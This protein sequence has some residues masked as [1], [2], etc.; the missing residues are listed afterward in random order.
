MRTR[1][2]TRMRETMTPAIIIPVA[3]GDSEL[4]E[5]PEVASEPVCEGGGGGG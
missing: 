1:A 2:T 4:P 3:V 5:L